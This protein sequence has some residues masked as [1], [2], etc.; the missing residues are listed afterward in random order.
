MVLWPFKARSHGAIVFVC[1]Y[2]FYI[3]FLCNLRL[4]VYTVQWVWMRLALYMST[5]KHI[6]FTGIAHRNRT[7]WMWNLNV[8]DIAH[9]SASHWHEIAPCEH[10]HWHL[11]NPFSTSQSQTKKSH[12]VNEPLMHSLH[13]ALITRYSIR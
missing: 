13:G 11:H 4:S 10:P 8:C 7:E 3:F 2:D 1:D 5:G 6:A 9:T 12:H